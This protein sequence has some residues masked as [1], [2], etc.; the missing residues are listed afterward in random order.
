MSQPLVVEQETGLLDSNGLSSFDADK[1]RQFLE[2]LAE[3]PHYGGIRKSL[4]AIGVG[5]STFWK[6]YQID[7]SLKQS[8]EKLKH[9]FAHK[10]EQVLADCALDPKKTID[11]IF[12]LKTNWAEKYDKAS[13]SQSPQVQINLSL[14]GNPNPQPQA[15]ETTAQYA[16]IPTN[17]PT[18]LPDHSVITTQTDSEHVPA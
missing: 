13:V 4:K 7:A 12:Y 8:I 6:H 16:Q 17:P 18:A 15:L 14:F 3:N 11:R 9:N 1:K 2:L 5:E 10:V